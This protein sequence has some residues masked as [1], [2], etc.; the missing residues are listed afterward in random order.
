MSV[1]GRVDRN[2]MQVYRLN[3]EEMRRTGTH[4]LYAP[5]HRCSC[6]HPV[7][8][9]PDIGCLVCD[10]VGWY[11]LPEEERTIRAVVQS[12]SLHRD[13]VAMGIVQPGDLVVQFDRNPQNLAPWDRIRLDPHQL[14]TFGIPGVAALVTRGHGDT[15]TLQYRVAKVF[16]V[17]RSEPRTGRTI[18][19]PEGSYR[20]AK[21]TN[22]ITWLCDPDTGLAPHE[23]DQYSINY[24][25]DWDW[26]VTEPTAPSALGPVGFQ[27][28][29]PI[30][31]RMK[32][33]RAE[34]ELR[35][36]RPPEDI[37]SL[38]EELY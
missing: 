25:V 12:G 32:D 35:K 27:G 23:G 1:Y 24:L 6:L 22:V 8:R 20:V 9:Q 38:D 4:I 3:R 19:Y 10:G 33:E 37:D 36:D 13:L 7:T 14:Y 17:D 2:A 28:R 11:W 30:S 5:R 21:N 18:T 26:I 16:S 31:R 34:D 29:I 15:D